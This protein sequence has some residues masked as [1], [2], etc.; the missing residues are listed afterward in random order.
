MTTHSRVSIP[1]IEEV[2]AAKSRLQAIV[3]STPLLRLN[4]EIPG[5]EIYLKCEQFQPISSFKLRPATNAIQFLSTE[6]KQNGIVTA[7][8]GNMA[9]GLAYIARQE[10]IQCKVLV[11]DTANEVKVKAIERLGGKVTKCTFPEWWQVVSTHQCPMLDGH[12]IHPVCNRNIIAGNATIALEILDELPD[13]DAI[14]G[15]SID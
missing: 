14:I 2:Y 15:K 10:N 12:F 1:S 13:C 4:Y 7:S 6:E 8:A 3:T 9:Q 5:I 11:P